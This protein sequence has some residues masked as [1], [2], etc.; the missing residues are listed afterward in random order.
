MRRVHDVNPDFNSLFN[1][2]GTDHPFMFKMYLSDKISI[3]TFIV[4]DQILNFSTVW[5]KTL[6]DDFIW[7]DK[8]NIINKY[9]SFINI[10]TKQFKQILRDMF[11]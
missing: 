3:E 9:K 5:D 11:E 7:K 8:K 6:S 10:D 4:L 2:D 1:I